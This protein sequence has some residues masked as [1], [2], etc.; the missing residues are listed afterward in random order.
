MGKVGRRERCHEATES[1]P[2]I[3]EYLFGGGLSASDYC[4][5]EEGVISFRLENGRVY[6]LLI[7][8]PRLATAVRRR[9]QELG[10]GKHF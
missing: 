4:M 1:L 9:L 5:P 7:D 3:N 8:Q 10:I 6:D 2:D